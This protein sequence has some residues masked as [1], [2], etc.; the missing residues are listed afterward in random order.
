[1][2]QAHIVIDL[3]FGDAGKGSMVDYLTRTLSSDLVVRFN[4]GAQAAHNVVTENSQHVFRQFGSGSFVG[5]RTL[6]S[7]YALFDPLLLFEEAKSL[8]QKGVSNPLAHMY[9][10]EDCVITT[11]YQQAMNRVRETVRSDARHGSCGLGIGE[12]A[13]D[14]EEIP[15]SVL[16]VSDLKDRARTYQ[17]L[18]QL[19]IHKLTEAKEI[20]EGIT[21]EQLKSDMAILDDAQFSTVATDAYCNIV[22]HVSVISH[23]EALHLIAHAKNPLFEGAQGVL[24]DQDFGFYPYITRSKVVPYAAAALC[25]DAGIDYLITGLLRAYTVRHGPGPMLTFDAR[26]TDR[27]PDTHNTFGEW[28]REFRVG[29][30]DAMM[31]RLALDICSHGSKD[32]KVN[33]LFMTCVDRLSSFD[34]VLLCDRYATIA[35]LPPLSLSA[36][37]KPRK[38]VSTNAIM[39]LTPVYTPF[40]SV[41][42]KSSFTYQAE[43]AHHV[44]RMLKSDVTLA[45]ISR[46]VRATDK[47][48]L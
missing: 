37:G 13:S 27:V 46:G 47:F 3:G 44:H 18:E 9:V 19:R 20:S 12:T 5:A 11:I 32:T 43:Y 4:G 42:E 7:K 14:S 29:Y 23:D 38:R 35:H 24:L 34:E 16:R 39:G 28:Q 21:S 31:A 10:E 40:A 17:K 26:L 15:D 8:E 45:G 2:A 6:Y 36:V 1:M 48:L 25:K 30:F 22:S 41:H 33:S